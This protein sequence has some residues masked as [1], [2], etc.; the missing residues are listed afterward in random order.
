[1]KL[2]LSWLADWVDVPWDATE[3]C[4]RLTASG[5]E[6]E[7]VEPAAPA[8]TGVVVAE[9]TA[10]APHPDAEKLRVCQVNAGG[11]TLQIVCGAP[12]ARTGLRAPLARVGALLPG[13]LRIKAAR[14]R[15]IESAGMLCSARELGLTTNHT[16]LMELPAN[17][18]VGQDLRQY[19]A[20]DDAVLELKTYANRGDSMS[21]L[22]VAREVVALTGGA[23][24]AP[25]AAAFDVAGVAGEAPVVDAP[26]AAPRL[27]IRRIRGLDNRGES[28]PWLAERLRRAG[29]RSIS[30]VVDVTNYV[31]IELGQPMHAY[32]ASLVRGALHARLARAGE[33]LTLLDER[34]IELAPDVLVIADDS[35]PVALAGVMGGLA[36]SITAGSTDVLLEVAFFAPDA[37]AGRGRRYGVLTDGGQRF[38][39]GVDPQGQARAMER[40]TG[41]LL[42]LC[43]G[44]AGPVQEAVSAGHLPVRAPVVLRRARLALLS[45]AQIADHDVEHSLRGLGM[46]VTAQQDGWLVVPPS[47]R[48]DISIEADLIEEVLRIVGFDAVQEQPT[49]L[50]QRFARRSETQLDERALLDALTGRGYQEAINYAFVDPALQGK[51][52]PGPAIRLANPIA[53]DLAVMRVSLWPGLLKAALENLARQQDRVRLFERGAVFHAQGGAVR[54]T[55]HIGG[56]AV[57]ARQPEQ[58]AAGKETADFFDL[59]ADVAALLQLAGAAVQFSWRPAGIACLHPGRSAAVARDG[60]EI[61]WLGELHPRLAD[62][63][64]FTAPCLLFEVDIAAALAAP[65]PALAPVSRFPQVRRDLSVTVPLDTPLSALVA[66]VSVVAGSLLRDLTVFDVYQGAGIETTR[67]SIAFG[68]I[69]QD[70]NKTLTDEDADAL[71]ASVAADLGAQLDARIRN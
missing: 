59:K 67:K 6:V 39:R 66:R 57:G 43:G 4:R 46:R 60:R 41:L 47:W 22:G 49:R 14:L 61:G 17:A 31:L 21:V 51:L 53:A 52:F 25:P 32:D 62:E 64:G 36:T 56:I 12:N 24:K 15:G 3:L 42:Q 34:R 65:L 71:M 27:L 2:P 50:P 26:Q 23:L 70:N 28:P 30:P 29:L 40:A 44:E 68:L 55:L 58:W 1:M 13:E 10:I 16:G 7:G 45:G 5:F 8:F 69:F 11:E 54:E 48:F 63:L 33:P 35:G 18:P 19:L 20:L 9:I 37:V 38:E